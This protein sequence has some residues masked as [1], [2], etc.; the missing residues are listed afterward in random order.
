MMNI[1]DCGYCEKGQVQVGEA[2]RFVNCPKCRGT[3]HVLVDP[4]E[5]RR[6]IEEQGLLEAAENRLRSAISVVAEGIYAGLER[7]CIAIAGWDEV[8]A[9]VEPSVHRRAIRRAWALERANN[10]VVGLRPIIAPETLE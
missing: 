2:D 4:E 6:I 8:P 5:E 1:R 3:G 10:I 7:D 9:G